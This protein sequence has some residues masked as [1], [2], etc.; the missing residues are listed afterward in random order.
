MF[1]PGTE[2]MNLGSVVDDLFADVP[3]LFPQFRRLSARQREDPYCIAFNPGE[4]KELTA[5][6]KALGEWQAWGRDWGPARLTYFERAVGA[7]FPEMHNLTKMLRK[8]LDV[9][10]RH[11]DGSD[12]TAELFTQGVRV[13]EM[14]I[15]TN[16]PIEFLF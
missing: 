11:Y 5:E 6:F 7:A 8:R 4:A 2:L 1:V 9:F 3:T 13:C 16:N 10:Q 15:A 14:S 12:E